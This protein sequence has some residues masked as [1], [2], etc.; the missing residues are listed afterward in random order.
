MLIRILEMVEMGEKLQDKG[1]YEMALADT[2][3]GE[4]LREKD[5]T[6]DQRDGKCVCTYLRCL[7]WVKS[8][9]TRVTP[10]VDL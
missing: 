1:D 6:S 2:Q 8:S 3:D 10:K 4:M 5:E 7:R 9:R